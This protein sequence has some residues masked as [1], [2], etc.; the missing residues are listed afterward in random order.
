MNMAEQVEGTSMAL[1]PFV[2]RVVEHHHS[3]SPDFDLFIVL[4]R[5]EVLGELSCTQSF[6]VVAV[7]QVDITLQAGQR[8][9]CLLNTAEGHITKVVDAI[10]WANT[11]VPVVD[12]QFIMLFQRA[13]GPRIWTELLDS[14]VAEVR[15]RG[16]PDVTHGLP[17]IQHRDYA[18]L[19]APARCA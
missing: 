17:S 8:S 1:I 5:V 19:D 7:D 15:V 9:L 16:E 12:Q 4:P 3:L 14:V 13:L 11:L 10:T 18:V 2:N 6:I